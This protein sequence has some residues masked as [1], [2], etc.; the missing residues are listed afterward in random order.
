[1]MEASVDGAPILMDVLI[2]LVDKGTIT[3]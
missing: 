3:Q 2:F 1:M